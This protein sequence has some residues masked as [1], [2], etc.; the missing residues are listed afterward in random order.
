M[1][2]RQYLAISAATLSTTVA[3]C[4]F[5][6]DGTG[7]GTP[8]ETLSTPERRLSDFRSALESEEYVLGEVALDDGI[9]M[10]EYESAAETDAAVIEESEPVVGAFLGA[11]EDGMD[12][13]WLE[14]WLID[15]EGEPRAVYTVHESWARE[16]DEGAKSDE[17]FFG[18]IE[19]SLS[20]Q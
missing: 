16:W 9:L 6:G 11:L 12:A 8:T 20:W 18:R 17:E 3:G 15:A 2:R 19:E 1:I 5:L 7:D 10:V 4:G 13:E 14:A